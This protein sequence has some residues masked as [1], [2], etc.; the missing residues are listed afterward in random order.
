MKLGWRELV[1]RPSR[2]IVAGG[3]LT[4]IVVLLL[5]LGGL[6]DGLT[7]AAT[8]A[9]RAQ[10][11]DVIVY[12]QESRSSL[13]RSRI[14]PATEAQIARVP[15]VTSVSGIGVV[16]IGGTE[17]GDGDPLD[18]AVFGYEEPNAAVPAPPEPGSGFADA[19]L[20]ADGVRVGDTILVGPA[21]VPVKIVGLVDDTRYLSQSGLWVH[22]DTW[23][24]VLVTSRPD[25]SLAPDTFQAALVTGEG[26]PRMLAERI[27]RQ[28]SGTSA[29]TL[30]EAIAAL[31]GV[32]AQQTTFTQIITVTF[33][34]AGLVVAL[35]FALV[36]LER[37]G[38][39]GVL[40]AVGASSR[41]LAAGLVTQAVLVA[42]GAFA[43]GSLVAYGLSLV[44]PE[45][46]PVD[47]ELRRA[48]VTAVGVL[49][50]ALIGSAISFRKIVRVDPASAVGG[51]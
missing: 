18:L 47:L 23:H 1:R 44:I 46:V 24:E 32:E 15:G 20:E 17:Q 19:G 49:V 27:E 50:T 45:E 14:E 40:K 22:P 41:Q 42:L 37:L 39:F 38:L 13:L 6:L 12:S 34:V 31:P 43:L 7:K 8:G 48:V 10:T 29:L 26:D 36:V 35:F 2:F 9:Y 3:A 28:V 33:V 16:L 51:S 11:A 4:L 5:L 30:D 21:E 25:A